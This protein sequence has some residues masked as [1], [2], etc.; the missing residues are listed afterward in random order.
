MGV[1]R[2]DA[3]RRFLRGRGGRMSRS[4]IAPRAHPMAREEFHGLRP[5]RTGDSPRAIHWR[6]SARRG[7]LTV[8]EYED[9]TGEDFLLAFDPWA[10][11]PADFEAA[12]SL[13]ATI[14]Y[15]WC[16][17]RGDRLIL[18][19]PGPT[20]LLLDGTTGPDHARRV[21]ECLALAELV[22]GLPVSPNSFPIGILPA[23]PAVIV[24]AGRGGAADEIGRA[25]RRPAIVLDA[26]ERKRFDFY[27]P[28]T[29][30][31]GA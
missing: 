22:G 20:P 19:Y 14:A 23:A 21:L 17:R 30:S 28:P 26:S 11:D 4:R 12:V 18:Y 24:T 27:E 31:P 15:E 3:F 16:R 5:F 7:E 13:A 29:S 1:L 8:R 25:L 9:F 10:V 2:R 6:T